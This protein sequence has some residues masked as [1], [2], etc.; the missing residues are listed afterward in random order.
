MYLA[1]GFPSADANRLAFFTSEAAR[2]G[3]QSL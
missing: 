2:V 3:Q 1:R